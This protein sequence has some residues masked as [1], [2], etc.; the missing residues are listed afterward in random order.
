MLAMLTWAK[1]RVARSGVSDPGRAGPGRQSQG[2]MAGPRGRPT[3]TQV[4]N[5]WR[6]MRPDPDKQVIDEL[7]VTPQ[8]A[9]RQPEGSPQAAE[10]PRTGWQ[11]A[12]D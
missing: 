8:A 11:P 10:P 2:G 12:V 1:W 7:A 5:A 9:R 3:G 4:F 6:R